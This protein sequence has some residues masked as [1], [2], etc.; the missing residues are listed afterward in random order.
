MTRGDNTGDLRMDAG[1]SSCRWPVSR[2]KMVARGPPD[3]VVGPE[4]N[5]SSGA[6]LSKMAVPSGGFAVPAEDHQDSNAPSDG[7]VIPCAG[8]GGVSSS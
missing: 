4:A 8:A 5:V 1:F 2:E 6:P 7:V 3:R